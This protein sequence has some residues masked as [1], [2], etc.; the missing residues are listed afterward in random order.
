MMDRKT[1]TKPKSG[2][3]RLT[4]REWG[5]LFDDVKRLDLSDLTKVE[6]LK[7]ELANAFLKYPTHTL[8]DLFRLDPKYGQQDHLEFPVK[9]V[10]DIH[11]DRVSQRIALE[12]ENHFLVETSLKSPFT[13]R[14]IGVCSPGH[15]I[16]SSQ[17]DTGRTPLDVAVMVVDEQN[18]STGRIATPSS[19]ASSAA[20]TTSSEDSHMAQRLPFFSSYDTVRHLIARCPETLLLKNLYGNTPYR[21]RIL[22]LQDLEGAQDKSSDQSN[23][24][25]GRKHP[26]NLSEVS[27]DDPML[28][29][30]RTYVIRNFNHDEISR[31]LYLPGEGRIQRKPETTEVKCE[32]NKEAERQIEFTMIGGPEIIPEGFLGQLE[33]YL[34]FE[35][36]LRSVILPKFKFESLQQ[37][38]NDVGRDAVRMF[39]WLRKRGVRKILEIV[40][41][42]SEES[43][44]SDESIQNALEGFEVEI[45]DWRRSDIT[46]SV[47]AS[48]SSVVKDLTLY[49]SGNET[50][51]EDW[52]GSGGFA[53]EI[54]FPELRR[55]TIKGDAKF[56]G[57]MAVGR[58]SD[59]VKKAKR[60]VLVTFDGHAMTEQS[61]QFEREI[62]RLDGKI[63]VGKSFSSNA[64]SGNLMNPWFI[65]SSNR[66]TYMA[67]LICRVCPMVQLYVARL[68]EQQTAE[69]YQGHMTAKS[70]AKAIEWATDC[71][72]DII[73]MSWV[74]KMPSQGGTELR[75]FERAVV[76]A[77][78]Q[79][80]IM[81]CSSNDQSSPT[82]GYEYLSDDIIEIASATNAGDP[83][84]RLH[85][86]TAHFLLPG[87]NV[88]FS[89]NEGKI[90]SHESG[91]GIATA[92]ASGLAALLIFSSWLLDE[93]DM[94]LTGCRG[95]TNAFD[96]LTRGNKYPLVDNLG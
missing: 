47:I 15:P 71:G 74:I 87:E 5:L 21:Q 94:D 46:S 33:R 1:S 10:L 69:S 6:D 13:A 7:G 53:N 43:S 27:M 68:H 19:A 89:N 17:D 51:L 52:C 36:T 76:M 90:V 34:A 18:D 64:N 3:K 56:Q 91:S 48:S 75:D 25:K 49:F 44:H 79:R 60:E 59:V 55:I 67:M 93:N 38:S 81:F 30:I 70:A 14:I 9:Q 22:L 80:I 73:S 85:K 32:F 61:D 12:D 29:Y 92:A 31:V 45:W 35:S 4:R 37:A 78:E 72:V 11:P 40:V 63:A 88:P 84:N 95:M 28:S 57:I 66:G 83:T 62:D 24:D 82:D 42:D 39:S 54:L 16:F 23:L 86:D 8:D 2:G 77:K 65:S 58:L 26:H 50:I 20:A 96:N 41:I